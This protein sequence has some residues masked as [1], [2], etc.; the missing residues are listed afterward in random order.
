MHDI[1]LALDAANRRLVAA[2]DGGVSFRWKDYRIEGPGR[3]KTMTLT[4]HEFIRRFLIHV[5]PTGFH[6]IRHYGLLASGNRAVY[7]ARARELLAVPTC[8][9]QPD[10]SEPAAIDDAIAQAVGSGSN[11]FTAAPTPMGPRQATA[12][13]AA[14]SLSRT[15]RR[16]QIPIAS[17][18]PP[19]ATLPAISCL[20][21]FRTPAS[22]MP[23][24]SR[25]RRHPKTCTQPDKF[26]T[27]EVREGGK[28][29][30]EP[31]ARHA[32]DSGSGNRRQSGI[33]G[34]SGRRALQRLSWNFS[35]STDLRNGLILLTSQIRKAGSIWPIRAMAGRASSFFP[36][37]A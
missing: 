5:L 11:L 10:T 26:D 35:R 4:P 21:A 25:H 6:R 16:R 14:V 13:P 19:G 28:F 12:P 31:S 23:A 34:H 7:I 20:G 29:N 1:A 3:W 18:P 24:W 8:S 27:S 36:I 9:E 37:R 30:R 2:D 32:E 33:N 15:A 22:R 17:A